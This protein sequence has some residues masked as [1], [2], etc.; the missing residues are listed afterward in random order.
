VRLAGVQ[1][2]AFTYLR[3]LRASWHFGGA[4]RSRD[5]ER[6]LSGYRRALASIDDARVDLDAPW[7]RAL[8]PLALLRGCE[9]AQKLGRVN[10]GASLLAR[11]RPVYRRWLD[12]PL[13]ESERE[14]F[15]RL[16]KLRTV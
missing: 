13:S 7:C 11:W 14:L 8:I 6:A 12:R 10:E 4:T 5:P 15:D 3:S 1:G 16:E 2:L 9:I